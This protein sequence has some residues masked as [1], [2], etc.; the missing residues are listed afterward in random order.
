MVGDRP[1]VYA[2]VA[3]ERR[4]A[5]RPVSK[6]R[7]Q[8]HANR[9]SNRLDVLGGDVGVRGQASTPYTEG[10]FTYSGCETF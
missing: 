2:E 8:L 3:R 1:P 7:E 4:G 10:L 5:L 6:G 9:V